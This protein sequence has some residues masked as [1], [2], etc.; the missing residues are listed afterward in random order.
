MSEHK[1][2]TT[3]RPLLGEHDDRVP[4]LSIPPTSTFELMSKLADLDVDPNWFDIKDKRTGT[5]VSR[6]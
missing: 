2:L 6:L 5:F 1:D 3:I 4:G